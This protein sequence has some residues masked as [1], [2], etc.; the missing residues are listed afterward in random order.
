MPGII[1]SAGFSPMSRKYMFYLICIPIRLSLV[2][3]VFKFHDNTLFRIATFLASVFSVYSNINK[4]A[5]GDSVWWNR[6]VHTIASS[7]IAS[8]VV[9]SSSNLPGYIMGADVLFGIISSVVA[10]PW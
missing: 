7:L 3:L 4:I 1:E 6:E 10:N 2:G 9:I 5:G 8:S